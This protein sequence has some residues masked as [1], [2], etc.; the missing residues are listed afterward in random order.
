MP[1]RYTPHFHEPYLVRRSKIPSQFPSTS[2]DFNQEQS[3][4]IEDDQAVWHK[5]KIRTPA[6]DSE[7]TQQL[8]RRI[9]DLDSISA[10]S[11][12]IALSVAM[13][14]IRNAIINVCKGPSVQQVLGIHDVES[15]HC[16]RA[17]EVLAIICVLRSCI[18]YVESLEVRRELKA[19]GLHEAVGDDLES[20]CQWLEA[21][22]LVGDAR[23]GPEVLQEAVLGIREPKITCVVVLSDIIERG[24]V[25]RE[26]VVQYLLE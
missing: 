6:I 2:G 19:V 25:A 16:S 15:V 4:L 7:L 14:A 10:G 1:N 23:G 22:D 17:G 24:E 8:P 18:R 20:A 5:R 12:H 13:D 21:V 9:E 11:E 26:E 3:I